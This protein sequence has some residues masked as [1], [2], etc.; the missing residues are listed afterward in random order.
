MGASVGYQAN[1]IFLMIYPKVTMRAAPSLVQETGTNY[2]KHIIMEDMICL[3]VGV[4]LE[5][6]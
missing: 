2:Y 1:D 6:S 5:Y 3:I 4:F